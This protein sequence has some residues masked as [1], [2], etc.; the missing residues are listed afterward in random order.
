MSEYLKKDSPKKELVKEIILNLHKGLSIEE[1]KE[2]LGLT[3]EEVLKYWNDRR[4][5]NV[6]KAFYRDGTFIVIDDLEDALSKLRYKGG[7]KKGAKSP[8]PSPPKSPDRW[9]EEKQKAHKYS[10]LRDWLYAY[11][12]E[13]SDMCDVL[14]PKDETC[15]TCYG[16]GYTLRM[17]PTPEGLVPFYNRCQT[18]YMAK[19]FRVVRF[20]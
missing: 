6:Y 15:P 12:A 3:A 4:R 1:A 13:K 19:F 9:W 7:G 8:R 18:C 16:K 10:D 5:K 17:Y 2:K 14:E 11:W 20:Q